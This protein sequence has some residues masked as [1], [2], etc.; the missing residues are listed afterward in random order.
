MSLCSHCGAELTPGADTACHDCGLAPDAG[1]PPGL[2]PAD[3]GDGE[4]GFEMATWG[5]A[6]RAAVGSALDDEGVPWRWDPGALLVVR[7]SDEQLAESILEELAGEDDAD[8]WAE[9]GTTEDVDAEQV[10]AAMGD[11]FLVVDRL[12]HTPWNGELVIELARLAAIVE[13]SDPPF[14]VA[15]AMWREVGVRAGAVVEAAGEGDEAAVGDGAR[16]LRELLREYV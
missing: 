12:Q 13:D 16:A 11:V 1:R 14:G 9:A 3:G 6:D 15:R 4:V 2:A 5:A 8:G 10:H 7:E